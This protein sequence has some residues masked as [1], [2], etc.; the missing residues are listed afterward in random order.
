MKSIN[1]KNKNKLIIIP[2][3][4]VLSLIV[5][6]ASATY[7]FFSATVISGQYITGTSASVD[8]PLELLINQVSAGT[9]LLIPMEDSLIQSYVSGSIGHDKCIDGNGDTVCKVYSIKV[10]NNSNVGVNITGSLSFTAPNMPNLKW[11]KGTSAIT[12]FPT[13]NNGP[14][15][16]SFNTFVTNNATTTQTTFLDDTL[17]GSVS[18]GNNT[19]TYYISVWISEIGSA[20]SD[21]GLFVGTASFSVYTKTTNGNENLGGISSTFN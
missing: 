11:A 18:S 12:G 19:K 10:T 17:L 1:K 9:G 14:F 2:V 21:N 20:Q 7:A 3:I 16:S 8:N 6:I 5:A 15:Y 4:A 13:N